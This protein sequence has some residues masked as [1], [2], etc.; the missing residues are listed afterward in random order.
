MKNE[1][2]LGVAVSVLIALAMSP[3][4]LRAQDSWSDPFPGVRRL[5]R[6]TSNQDVQVLVVDL[7]ASGVSV[8]ATG[9]GERRRT[10]SSFGALVGAQAAVN[11]DFFSFDTYST[12]GV[13]MSGGA[14][15]GGS[16]HGYVA[17]VAFGDR[18]VEMPAHEADGAPEPWMREV[19]SGHPTILVDGAVRDSD[20]PLC[21]NRHPRTALGLSADRRTL[22]VAV[23]DGR[24]STRIGMRCDEVAVMLRDLG[25]DDVTNMDGGGSSA[26]WL[27]GSGVVSHP[28]DGRERV[29]ANHFAIVATGAGPAAHCPDIAPE[30]WLDS[31]SCDEIRGWT[32]DADAPGVSIDA[33]VYVGG[34]AGDPLAVGYP[35]HADRAR[36]DLCA[37]LGHC[38]HG[39]ALRVPHGFMDGVDRPVFAYGI[40][41]SGGVNAQLAGAPQILRCDPP[42]L[43]HTTASGVRRHVAS[44][45]IFAAW[46]FDWNDVM[47]IEDALLD[48]YADG[49][50]LPDAPQLLR[51]DA[52]PGV[53]LADGALRRH[54][55]SPDAMDAW[56][57]DWSAITAVDAEAFAAL[58]GGA[59]LDARPWLVRGS[60][61]AV[62]VIDAAPPQPEVPDAG[63]QSPRDAATAASA[64]PDRADSRGLVGSCTIAA[65]ASARAPWWMGAAAQLA[66]IARVVRARR[67]ARR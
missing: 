27:A 22:F 40:G 53:Y 36:D 16:D 51:T 57:F 56:N 7:C 46:K 60:G 33:H 13:S 20:D 44:P 41:A 47:T 38:A 39:F 45:E 1:L 52:D 12:D 55:P 63:V 29:V 8:R 67:V 9:G 25:A 18:R 30:G 28:S 14:A 3:S 59:R 49:A 19:V 15:W 61:A 65:G 34:P 23:I 43:A 6:R 35:L 24:S 66:L 32:R 42:A 31:A 48:A 5:H 50:P 21:T 37:A 2:A 10:P 64:T 26:M 11:G 62:Y 4:D 58:E 54:V 17:P